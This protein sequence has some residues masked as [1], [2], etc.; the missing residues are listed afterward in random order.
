MST[1]GLYNDL[2]AAPRWFRTTSAVAPKGLHCVSSDNPRKFSDD[3]KAVLRWHEGGLANVPRQFR[4]VSAAMLRWL[5]RCSA[6]VPC[7]L[8]N[9]SVI[10]PWR[11]CGG[12]KVAPLLHWNDK[13]IVSI[14]LLICYT[15]ATFWFRG[16][17][18]RL[19]GGS[20]LASRWLQGGIG[21]F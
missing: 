13:T 9:C 8:R 11:L 14:Y 3:S 7:W 18:I 21:A 1:Q 5:L 20:R 19:C 10:K 15:A 2:G 4:G 6:V 17:S 16:I 12:S